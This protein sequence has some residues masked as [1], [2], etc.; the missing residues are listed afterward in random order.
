[1]RNRVPEPTIGQLLEI[2]EHLQKK[3]NPI[4]GLSDDVRLYQCQTMH[5]HMHSLCE[6][7]TTTMMKKNEGNESLAVE[8]R[9][10]LH[11]ISL[12]SWQILLALLK[13]HPCTILSNRYDP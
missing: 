8:I 1:M 2:Q 11:V 12:R 5:Q 6:Y 10:R 3:S 4:Q 7:V 13:V 9:V